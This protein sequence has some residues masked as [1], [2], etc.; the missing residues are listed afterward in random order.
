MSVEN[1][2][3]PFC[4]TNTGTNLLTVSDYTAATGRTSGQVPGVASS[5]LNNTALRQATYI[6]SQIA[7]FIAN[8][9]NTGLIDNATPAQL[10]SQIGATL[11]FFPPVLTTLLSGTG[12]LNLTY[13]FMIATGNA[14]AAATYSDGTTTFTVTETI[15]SGLLLTATGPTAPVSWGTLTKLTGT[16]DATI[17]YYATR[18]PIAVRVRGSAGGGGGGGSSNATDGGTGGAG[19]DSSFGTGLISLTHGAGGPGGTTSGGQHNAVGGGSGS[20][21]TGPVG[22]LFAGGDGQQVNNNLG[23]YGEGRGGGT[24]MFGGAGSGG[25]PGQSGTAG[26]ANTGA[27]GGG[28]GCATDGSQGGGGGGAGQG[29]D[30]LLSAANIAVSTFPWVVGGGGTAG[31]A[32]T[33]GVVGAVGG[34]GFWEVTQFYQ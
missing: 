31:A 33:G 9:T 5:Q 28:A 34:S 7:Q 4:P 29:C 15:S 11:Q 14:T 6:T 17:T 18:A 24:G 20:L 19:S 2:F 8:I 16:G 12:T 21:G 27:G 23:S 13:L 32:G 25:S 26:K 3:L 10:L 30:C 22:I 1:D